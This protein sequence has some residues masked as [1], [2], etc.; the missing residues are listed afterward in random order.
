MIGVVSRPEDVTPSTSLVKIEPEDRDVV[1]LM[2]K[3]GSCTCSGDAAL[4]GIGDSVIQSQLT[5]FD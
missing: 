3:S 1:F 4:A 2:A 5:G